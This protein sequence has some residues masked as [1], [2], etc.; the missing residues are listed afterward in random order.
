MYPDGSIHEQI[1]DDRDGFKYLNVTMSRVGG[2][3]PTRLRLVGSAT[4]NDGEW[5]DVPNR[6][7]RYRVVD[8]AL[9]ADD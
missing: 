5:W 1:V 7:E 3:D 4:P 2:M 8:G 6:P 9:V